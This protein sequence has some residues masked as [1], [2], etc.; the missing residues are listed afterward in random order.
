MAD[1][2]QG[3]VMRIFPTKEQL[4]DIAEVAAIIVFS[5]AGALVFLLP[6][7]IELWELYN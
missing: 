2:N 5:T 1:N 7:I 3:G 4:D 6:L